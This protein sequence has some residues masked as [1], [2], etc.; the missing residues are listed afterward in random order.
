MARWLDFAFEIEFN[1]WGLLAI[2][3][4]LIVSFLAAELFLCFRY[5]WVAGKIE[6]L[7]DSLDFRLKMFMAT[8]LI[9][10]ELAV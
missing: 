1:V 5:F 8:Y 9:D 4:I 3:K 10:S 2:K 7:K 6:F